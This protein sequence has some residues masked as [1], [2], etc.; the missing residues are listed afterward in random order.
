MNTLY[1]KLCGLSMAVLPLMELH[2]MDY[3]RSVEFRTF[4]AQQVISPLL[5]GLSGA[6]VQILFNRIFGVI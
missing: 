6:A 3:L 5:T 4:I 1:V 2:I